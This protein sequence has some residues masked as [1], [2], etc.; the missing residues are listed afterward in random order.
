MRDEDKQAEGL[1]RKTRRRKAEPGR[2]SLG[3]FANF[4]LMHYLLDEDGS[5]YDTVDRVDQ[6]HHHQL[7]QGSQ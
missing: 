6:G 5:T 7:Q 3:W 2:K 1:R 4:I